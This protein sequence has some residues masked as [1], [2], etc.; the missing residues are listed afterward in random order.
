MVRAI[1]KLTIMS[2]QGEVDTRCKGGRE[3]RGTESRQVGSLKKDLPG[4]SWL[5]RASGMNKDFLGESAEAILVRE[6]TM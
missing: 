5:S 2:V 1:G 3:D 6:A 4:R